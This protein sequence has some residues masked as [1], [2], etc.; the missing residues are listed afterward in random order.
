MSVQNITPVFH[1]S[2]LNVKLSWN[3]RGGLHPKSSEGFQSGV[4]LRLSHF[5]PYLKA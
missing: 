3:V 2:S 1:K 5:P 4:T